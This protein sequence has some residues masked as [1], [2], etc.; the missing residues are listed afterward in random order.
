MLDSPTEALYH[1]LHYIYTP[2]LL[3]VI[4]INKSYDNI[5]GN[6]SAITNV[7]NYYL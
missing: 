6:V 2:S 4:N 7:H 5:D 3:K 1:S